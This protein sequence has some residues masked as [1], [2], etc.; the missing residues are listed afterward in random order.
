MRHEW[1]SRSILAGYNDTI[2][3][4]EKHRSF[5]AQGPP[6]T[7]AD[8]PAFL[9]HCV[10]IWQRSSLE[11]AKV[12]DGMGIEYYDFLQPNQYLPGSK[13][14]GELERSPDGRAEIP[15]QGC[16][17][18]RLPDAYHRGP[19]AGRPRRPLPRP[20]GNLPQITQPTYRDNCCH[21][22][23]TGNELLA[24]EMAKAIGGR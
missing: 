17:R 2:K 16:R 11:L 20:D 12:C 6:A 24:V 22:N 14:M 13:P 8:L 3:L 19:R 5:T 4:R 9:R 18:N 1:L 15:G 21:L 7:F 10:G 23:P